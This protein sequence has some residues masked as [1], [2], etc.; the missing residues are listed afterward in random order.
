MI[1]TRAYII[2]IALCLGVL[3]VASCGKQH[4]AEQTVKNFVAENMKE[5]VET[6]RLDFGDLGTTRHI[7]DSLVAKMRKNGAEL[8]KNNM[9]ENM[10]LIS[11]FPSTSILCCSYK[12]ISPS[13]SFTADNA[14]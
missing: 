11:A 12:S 7:N 3:F 1:H 4:T 5:G 8:F 13:I 6:K 10:A 9:R 2:N 14:A